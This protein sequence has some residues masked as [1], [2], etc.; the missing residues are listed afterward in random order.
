[1]LAKI[2]PIAIRLGQQ[3]GQ[4]VGQRWPAKP[5]LDWA[6]RLKLW[7]T[8]WP[9]TVVLGVTAMGVSWGAYN[10]GL[11]NRLELSAYDLMV[12]LRGQQAPDSR[13]LIVGIDDADIERQERW[14]LADATLATALENLQKHQPAVIGIDIYRDLKFDPGHAA[15]IRQ[16]N[17]PNVVTIREIEGTKHPIGYGD[18]PPLDQ[19]SFNDVVLDVDGVVRRNLLVSGTPEKETL[20]SFPMQLAKK[21]YAPRQIRTRNNVAD[22]NQMDFG[23]TTFVP[24]TPTSGAYR[25]S[26]E[27]AQGYQIMLDYRWH[28][29]VAPELSLSQV[30]DGDFDPALVRDKVVLIGSVA[31]SLRD[32]FFTPH[33][34]RRS[35]RPKVPGIYIHAQA[36]LQIMDAVNGDRP[37]MGYWDDWQEFGWLLLWVIFGCSAS[38]FCKRPTV[39]MAVAILASG[40][41]T[42]AT[43]GLFLHS[44]VWIPWVAPTLGLWIGV[45][46]S[47]MFQ[48]HQARRQK[49]AMWTLLGQS[50]S[51]EI[52]TALWEHREHLLKAGRLPGQ[53]LTATILFADIRNF[54]PVAESME[55]E[56]LLDW[57]NR[58]L[59]LISE[60]VCNHGGAVDKFMGD[61][62][63]ALFGVPLPRTNAAEVAQDAQNAVDCALTIREGLGQ[64]NQQLEIQG[65]PPIHMRVGIYTGPIVVGSMGGQKRWE[66]GAVGSSVNVASRLESCVRDRQTGI[67][68]ILVARQTLIHLDNRFQVE[69]W[70]SLPLKGVQDPVE[71]YQ[72]LG[73]TIGQEHPSFNPQ[74]PILHGGPGEKPDANNATVKPWEYEG[75]TEA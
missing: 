2:K 37:L 8:Q 45:G 25:Y 10:C 66:Y 33:S 30:L 56:M 41:M 32:V 13:L 38:H 22:P 20:F 39:L 54:S 7:E 46:G 72:V 42:G 43:I 48:A 1:M 75:I 63:M 36:V 23:K 71:V 28:D 34:A 59:V 40:V 50:T 53:R 14:P 4:Q 5:L 21:F 69:A 35:D 44:L 29:N 31:D 68:R 64:L 15:F 24:L 70:G 16:L 6:N 55:P 51:P 19:V 17:V 49:Y 12:Q 58:Y 47:L 61:G 27:D 74:V 18:R 65:L 57:L 52:A 26:E 3:V 73:R 67:C 11:L 62:M 60:S 9:Q